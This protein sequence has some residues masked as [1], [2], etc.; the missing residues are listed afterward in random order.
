MS[1]LFLEYGTPRIKPEFKMYYSIK[2]REV[3]IEA[4][5]NKAL[6]QYFIDQGWTVENGRLRRPSS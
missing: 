3:E 2:N 1:A 4:D 6:V 5:M